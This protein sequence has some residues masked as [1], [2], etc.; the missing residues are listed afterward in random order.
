MKIK[1]DIVNL[2]LILAV[3]AIILFPALQKQYSLFKE[4]KLDGDVVLASGIKLSRAHWF[5]G[6]Y[7]Q[8]KEKYLN[9]NLGF[10]NF[11][12]RLNNQLYY[13]LFKKAN[14]KDVVVGKDG[15]LYELK[16]LITHAGLDYVGDEEIKNRFIKLKFIQDT[17]AKKGIHFALLFAPGKATFYPEYIP[18]PYNVPS[19]KTNYLK[20]IAQAQKTGV[21]FY[22]FNKLFVQLKSTAKYS[23]YPKTGTHWSTYAMYLAF[24]TLSRYMER[25]S[26]RKLTKFDYSNIKMSDSLIHPDAD[27]AKGMNLLF[28]LPHFTMAYPKVTWS[29]DT[30]Y[31]PCV[32]TVSDSYWMG[33]HSLDLPKYSFSKSEFWY[34]N[35]QLFNYNP[36]GKIY[37]VADYDLKE[38]IEKNNFVFIMSTEAS[39]KELGWGFIDEVY[40]LYKNGP[41]AYQVMKQN[42]KKNSEITQ[43]KLGIKGNNSWYNDIKQ[44]AKDKN[45]S[46]DYF[47]QL[48]ADYIYSEKHKNDPPPEKEE[49]VIK[50]TEDFKISIRKDKK[51][52]DS[53]TLK[54][55]EE[56][57]SVDSFI[58]LD[59]K[60]M[61][62]HDEK[63]IQQ[64]KLIEK[65]KV[66]V[67]VIKKD[68]K[69]LASIALKAKEKHISVDSCINMDARWM[70]QEEMNKK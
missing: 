15:F 36:E 39:L 10:H 23:L 62:E 32:L 61:V 55:K 30:A 9:D 12:V 41:E 33:I 53:I 47:L 13:S 21:H 34:Y 70:A 37:S 27:I 2:V 18:A 52:L 48:N 24:D 38:S 1:S 69:W 8:T 58:N 22:D 35:R 11:F 45:S 56:H 44:Q 66:F 54:A 28:D 65:T 63:H 5:N 64:Q 16:Y 14:A 51:W 29:T 7:A 40:A 43:I 31:K 57:I 68:K 17:L 67:I 50:R 42:R 26:D 19:T 6:T 3:I 4:P 46:V 60:W 20:Y 49:D 25:L 59:A